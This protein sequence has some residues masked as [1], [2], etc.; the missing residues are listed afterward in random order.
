M[1]Y[2]ETPG[3]AE[4]VAVSGSY[5]YIADN[6][7]GLR[8]IDI[9][10]PSSPT[11]VG[12]YNT[13]DRAYGVAVSD[14]YAYVV[15]GYSGLCVIDISTP[16]SPTEAGYYDTPSWAN[17]VAVSG[18]YAY[19][20]DWDVGLQIYENLLYGVEESNDIVFH[21]DLRIMQNPVRGNYIV[22]WFDLPQQDNIVLGLYN[23]LGQ[24]VRTFS[25]NQL[26]PGEHTF[27]L[28]TSGFASGIYFLRLENGF[29]NQSIKLAIIE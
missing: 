3:Y 9:S 2:Y 22:L 23:L 5:A 4:A 27:R 15:D 25:L 10:T 19:V 8:V 7:A 26:A 14:A 12:Y 1:G 13:P 21:L 17:A 28:P 16:S 20:A 29:T 11:E 18:A 24:R 6:Y